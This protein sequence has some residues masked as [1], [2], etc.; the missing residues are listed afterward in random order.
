MQ[1]EKMQGNI[2][3][4]ITCQICLERFQPAGERIPCK[5]KCPHIMC[6]QCAD[7]WLK[8]VSRLL[9]IFLP[10]SYIL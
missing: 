1:N 6:K 5:L 2:N 4:L 8:A 3:D 10:I 7:G 9:I